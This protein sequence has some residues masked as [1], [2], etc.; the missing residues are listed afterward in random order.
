MSWPKSHSFTMVWKEARRIFRSS[1]QSKGS[2][3]VA[4]MSAS[5]SSRSGKRDIL[6]TKVALPVGTKRVEAGLLTGFRM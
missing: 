6:A 3:L 5:S 1:I 2:S 4:R